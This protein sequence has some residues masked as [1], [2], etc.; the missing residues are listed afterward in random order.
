MQDTGR[1]T[2]G[3]Q[4]DDR[5]PARPA[6]SPPVDFEA[7]RDVHHPAYLGYATVHLGNG[8]AAEAVAQ[9]FDQLAA[10]WPQVLS[11]PD[12]RARAWRVLTARTTV[13]APWP[14]ARRPCPVTRLLGPLPDLEHDAVVLHYLLDYSPE[15]TALTMGADPGRVAYLLRDVLR[16]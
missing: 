15:E 9:V 8:R 10:E 11:E 4:G 6:P 5:A 3:R 14:D 1:H 7:F 13:H 2:A 12:P 16:R